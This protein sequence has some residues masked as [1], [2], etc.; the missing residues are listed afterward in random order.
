MSAAGDAIQAAITD[1]SAELDTLH[2]LALAQAT[3][4]GALGAQAKGTTD[5]ATAA[6]A[7]ASAVTTAQAGVTTADKDVTAAETKSDL[8]RA[9]MD[10][11]L[12]TPA[13]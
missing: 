10:K 6:A 5:A 1:L 11:L 9:A 12:A 2:A 13:A 3:L 4:D 8:S 7:L